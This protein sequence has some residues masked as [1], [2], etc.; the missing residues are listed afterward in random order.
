MRS[1]R[2][3]A[4]LTVIFG[5]LA[6][7]IAAPSVAHSASAT[8]VVGGTTFP[9]MTQQQM[10]M[11]T[12]TD[13]DDLVNVTYPAQL[14][15]ATEGLQLGPSVDIGTTNLLAAINAT[16]T[17]GTTVAVW[18]ISQ[19]ALVLDAAQRELATHPATAPA[20]SSLIFIRVADPANPGNGMLSYVPDAILSKILDY[21]SAA[22]SAPE[23]QYNTIII[24]NEYDG[25]ADWPDRPWNLVADLNALVGLYYRHGQ[26]AI[27]DLADAPPQ[28][29][30]TATNG[31]GAT[32]TTYL[33]P[34]PVIP[35]TQP[36]R[37]AGVSASIV[38]RIDSIVVPIIHA[39]YSRYDSTSTTHAS[40][41]TTPPC[42][43]PTG[44]TTAGPRS[45]R[46]PSAGFLTAATRAAAWSR[47]KSTAPAQAK[48]GRTGRTSRANA[49]TRGAAFH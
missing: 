24:T 14:W 2:T 46:Q 49:V 18:G 19:G 15:P 33:L 42:A 39:G 12:N 27:A 20:A 45:S 8:L 31:L 26:T 25:F 6:A 10:A 36:L 21:P 32:T 40:T 28:N 34:S 41:S 48:V 47:V 9:T 35:L 4:R 13:S 5:A 17:A 30:T 29:I 43:A 16:V 22:R 1:T 38:D 3:L 7:T 23:S 11:L 44:L 37:D